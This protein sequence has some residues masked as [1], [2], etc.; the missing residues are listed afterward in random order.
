MPTG[1]PSAARSSTSG[2]FPAA[3]TTVVP[4]RRARSAAWSLVEHAAGPQFAFGP[5]GCVPKR[6]GNL[7]LGNLV[8]KDR[9]RIGAGVGGVE[10]HLVGEEQQQVGV[11]E[12]GHQRRKVVVVAHP[13]LLGGDGVVFVDDRNRALVQQRGER[14]ARVQVAAAVGQVRAGEE[15][16]GDGQGVQA[17]DLLVERHQPRLADRRQHLLGGQP[18]GELGE[19]QPLAA[20]RHRAGGDQQHLAAA[21][22]QGGAF[23]ARSPPGAAWKDAGCR[24]SAWRCRA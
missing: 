3:I 2:I 7:G 18:F 5:L 17:E 22:A 24:P 20:G 23:G 14:V 16:L 4:E 10:P 12:V 6:L 15:N 11:D 19:A 1:S 13:D 9:V 21:L 8:D